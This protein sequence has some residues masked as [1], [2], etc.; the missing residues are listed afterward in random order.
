MF[1]QKAIHQGISLYLKE[2]N[3]LLDKEIKA[4]R[5]E[6]KKKHIEL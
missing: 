5:T 2:L 6:L 4:K 1:N 3:P